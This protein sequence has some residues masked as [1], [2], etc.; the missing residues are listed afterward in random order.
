MNFMEVVVMMAISMV[1]KME[2]ATME[3]MI[4]GRVMV[5]ITSRVHHNDNDKN[6]C[7]GDGDRSVAMKKKR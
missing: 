4:K 5:G 1:V 2:Q 7:G 3:M 6:N